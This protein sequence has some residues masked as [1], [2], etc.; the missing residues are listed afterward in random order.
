[1]TS[2]SSSEL[3]SR[4]RIPACAGGDGG[5]LTVPASIKADLGLYFGRAD[6]ADVRGRR[7]EERVRT[8]L[9]LLPTGELDDCSSEDTNPVDLGNA[10]SLRELRVIVFTSGDTVFSFL[11]ATAGLSVA[12]AAGIAL[13]RLED[14]LIFL[15]TFSFSLSAAPS[16][17]SLCITSARAFPT[18]ASVR[19]W[20]IELLVFGL[21]RGRPPVPVAEATSVDIA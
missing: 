7:L 8:R 19:E 10:D 2:F 12:A 20:R 13:L 16:L 18:F 14:S 5:V 11:A 1:M 4:R 6:P 15:P 17:V 21:E 3:L 9:G